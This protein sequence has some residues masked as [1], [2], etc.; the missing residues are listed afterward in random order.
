MAAEST[1]DD[2]VE[3]AEKD[4]D[5]SANNSDAGKNEWVSFEEECEVPLL[6]QPPSQRDNMN[7]EKYIDRLGIKIF[8]SHGLMDSNVHTFVLL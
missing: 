7:S 2:L 5:M 1:E 8:L 4:V 6:P 3:G